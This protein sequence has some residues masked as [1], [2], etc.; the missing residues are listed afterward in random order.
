[1]YEAGLVGYHNHRRTTMPSALTYFRQNGGL[2][3]YQFKSNK[4]L[5]VWSVKHI[6]RNTI[7][8]LCNTFKLNRKEVDT[9][10]L[11][12]PG[13]A[14]MYL[15]FYMSLESHLDMYSTRFIKEKSAGDTMNDHAI[16]NS[17]LRKT[18]ESRH[19]GKN[20]MSM[21][22]LTLSYVSENFV[23]LAILFFFILFLFLS[24]V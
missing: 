20:S 11:Y 21:F 9:F 22:Y 12:L 10:Y 17:F 19:H 3:L 5:R 8:S 13:I 18:V 16:T 23:I 1:M 4:Q 7:V 2:A 24:L 14:I 15:V 6:L